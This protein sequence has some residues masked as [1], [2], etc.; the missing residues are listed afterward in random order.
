[1]KK[2]VVVYLDAKTSYLAKW[3]G[4]HYEVE[5]FGDS[6]SLKRLAGELNDDKDFKVL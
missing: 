2:W 1:M 5:A 4:D 6:E 3:Y